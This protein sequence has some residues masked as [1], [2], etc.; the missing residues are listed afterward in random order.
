MV[1]VIIMCAVLASCGIVS[2]NVRFHSPKNFASKSR[3]PSRS[4]PWRPPAALPLNFRI[5]TKLDMPEKDSIE[6][7]WPKNKLPRVAPP[8]APRTVPAANAPCAVCGQPLPGF[9]PNNYAVGSGGI[10]QPKVH[11][12]LWSTSEYSNL[13]LTT[14]EKGIEY[15]TSYHVYYKN[16]DGP[17]SPWHDIPLFANEGNKIFNMVVEIPRWTNAKMEIST[18]DALNPIKQ[19][20]KKGRL[21]YTA[22]VYPHHGYIWNYGALPQTWEDPNHI[23]EATGCKGDNDPIDVCEIGFRVAKRGEVIQ[24]KIL[25]VVALIDEGETD[26]KLIAIDVN[27]PMAPQLSDISDVEKYMPG[28]LKATVEW[29]KIYKIPDGKPENQFAFNG[30]AKER[31][32]AHK[33]IMET[34][35]AWQNLVLGISDAG[36]LNISSV[37]VPNAK[38]KISVSDAEKI[39]DNAPESGPPQPIDPKV[40][41]WHYVTLK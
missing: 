25:G 6:D 8:V 35:E 7:S 2:N 11:V 40:D 36:G 21:R 9:D 34:H 41:L 13:S 31:D 27:D 29:F 19:D 39:V 4:V 32:F 33:V 38:F 20:I 1:V 15:N 16:D 23:D 10:K 24:V 14:V 12:W 37:V 17:L 3:F 5:T 30:D 26:W 18:K 22:N 28:Y